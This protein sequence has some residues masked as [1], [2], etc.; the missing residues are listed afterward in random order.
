MPFNF[1]PSE[2]SGLAITE[3]TPPV[4]LKETTM[5]VSSVTQNSYIFTT[6]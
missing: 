1:A 4:S 2:N 3:K 5:E 6:T